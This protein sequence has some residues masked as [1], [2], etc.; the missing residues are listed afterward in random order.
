SRVVRFTVGRRTVHMESEHHLAL[1]R[2]S[3]G[4][5]RLAIGLQE[6][7][8]HRPAE[9]NGHEMIAVEAGLIKGLLGGQSCHPEGRVRLLDWARQRGDVVEVMELPAQA[10]ILSAQKHTQCSKALLKT[11]AALVHGDTKDSKLVGQKSAR[12][13]DIE[14]TV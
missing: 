10:G 5:I 9:G 7:P 11:L 4:T 8:H 14:P 12:H 13:A 2:M 3:C 6:W 1:A